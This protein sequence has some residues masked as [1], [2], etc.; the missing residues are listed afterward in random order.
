[1]SSG[2]I[3]TVTRAEESAERPGRREGAGSGDGRG[4]HS[5]LLEE[6]AT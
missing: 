3:S 2:G 1:M 5:G 4:R 6:I